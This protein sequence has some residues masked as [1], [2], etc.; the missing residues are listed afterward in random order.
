MATETGHGSVPKRIAIVVGA[1]YVPGINAVIIG[2]AMA[3]NEMGLELVGIRDGLEGLLRPDR[4]PEGGL[5]TLNPQLIESL[6]P[7]AGAYWDNPRG[8]IRSMSVRSTRWKWWKKSICPMSSS[9]GS[10]TKR[11]T[12]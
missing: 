1:G 10:K 9:G 2:A 4:Y 6:D 7:S 3:A 5:V 12:A 8:L 11:L